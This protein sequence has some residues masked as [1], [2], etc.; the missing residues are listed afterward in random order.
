VAAFSFSQNTKNEIW[1]T[2]EYIVYKDSIVQQKKYIARALSATEIISNYQ[3]PANLFQS[4]VLSFK[5][6]INGKDN[7][8]KPGSD[9]HFS[10]DALSNKTPLIAN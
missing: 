9:H 5:F 6:S 2:K 3:S 10:C 8:M 4:S 1:R 7:E